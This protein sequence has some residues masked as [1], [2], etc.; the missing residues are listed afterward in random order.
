MLCFAAYFI[1]VKSV[2]ILNEFYVAE[3]QP[4]ISQ[5]QYLAMEMLDLQPPCGN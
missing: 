1:P 3:L 2:K 4:Q 5:T